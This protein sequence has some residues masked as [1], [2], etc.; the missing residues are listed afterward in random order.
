[1]Q[2]QF[3]FVGIFLLIALFFGVA[4]LFI[5]F[6][7]RPK[8]SNPRKASTYE[9][10]L[11]PRGGAWVQFKAQYY[12]FGLAFVVFDVEAVLLLP[13]AVAYKALDLYAV[14]EAILFVLILL[15]AL[16][17]IWRKGALEWM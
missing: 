9:C 1:M 12:L 17:Y 3:T 6:L 7:L 4:P 16:V 2:S 11:E 10:G 5:A 13:W 15:G 8:K 14:V